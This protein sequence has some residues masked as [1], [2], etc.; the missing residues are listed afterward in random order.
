[1]KILINN[2]TKAFKEKVIFSN[3]N[4]E[5]NNE[6]INLICGDNGVGK[7]TLLFMINGIDNNYSGE[8]SYKDLNINEITYYSNNFKLIDYLTVKENIVFFLKNK[9]TKFNNL[10]SK[11]DLNENINLLSGGELTL[12]S[13]FILF[14]LNFKCLLLDEITSELDHQNLLDVIDILCELTLNKLIIIATHDIRI[15]NDLRVRRIDL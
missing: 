7:T 2:L 4:I 10:I 15:M 5:F 8:I 3:L 9:K 14:N 1:M 12:L 13:L 6:K 11:L